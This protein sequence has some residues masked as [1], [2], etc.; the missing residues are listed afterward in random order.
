MVMAILRRAVSEKAAFEL[1]AIVDRSTGNPVPVAS[2][3]KD[4]ATDRKT[5]VVTS[6][7]T[8]SLKTAYL[9]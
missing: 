5:S 3:G 7:A 4:E 8:A 2:A 6:Q 9:R 1:I